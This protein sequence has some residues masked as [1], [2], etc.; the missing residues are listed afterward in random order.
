MKSCRVV[1]LI[2][3]IDDKLENNE[4]T[5]GKLTRLGLAY[6]NDYLG[7]SKNSEPLEKHIEFI[8]GIETGSKAYL[9]NQTENS[10]P[11]IRGKTLEARV[12]DIFVIPDNSMPKVQENDVLIAFDGAAGRTACG[13]VGVYS[14]GI[15]KAVNCSEYN[16]SNGFIYFY[17]N[18]KY[19][20]NIILSFSQART[21]IIHAGKSI[22]EM[23]LPIRDEIKKLSDKLSAIYNKIIS[24]YAENKNLNFLKQKYLQKFFG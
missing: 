6:I 13:L 1:D 3:S 5:I 20:Q 18:S 11:F 7:N 15:R 4:E 16:L 21:T 19:I 24:C 23:K 10:V 22:E 9:D 17:L 12:Y 8:K 2:G 14:S